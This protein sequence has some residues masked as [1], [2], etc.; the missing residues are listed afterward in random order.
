MQ[1]ELHRVAFWL[2][3]AAPD[4]RLLAQIVARLAAEHGAPAFTPHITLLSGCGREP[5]TAE[6]C[7]RVLRDVAHTPPMRLSV[8][9]VRHSDDFF[10]TVVLELDELDASRRVRERVRALFA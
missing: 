9:G 10:E 7:A 3:P 8:R 4:G 1:H 6:L 2:L 5:V